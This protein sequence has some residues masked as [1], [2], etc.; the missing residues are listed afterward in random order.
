[1]F[2][3]PHCLTKIEIPNEDLIYY[4]NSEFISCEYCGKYFNNP[5]YHK[6]QKIKESN[7]PCIIQKKEFKNVEDM[8]LFETF[9]FLFTLKRKQYSY[10]KANF[11]DN[12][13]RNCIVFDLCIAFPLFILYL[14]IHPNPT[15][16]FFLCYMITNILIIFYL[17]VHAYHLERDN[18]E[19]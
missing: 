14:A 10:Y 7:K 5:M 17:R 16:I 15:P 12:G 6:I 18:I 8:G 4:E 3:C 19:K 1:M 13:A 9:R 11:V 2:N